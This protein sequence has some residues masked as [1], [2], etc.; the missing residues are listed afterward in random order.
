M[1]I[2]LIEETRTINSKLNILQQPHV[3]T[4]S[5]GTSSTEPISS[6]YRRML[7]TWAREHCQGYPGIV[8]DDFTSSW[9]NG[10]AF[11]VILH[12]HK[13]LN[14]NF[15]RFHLLMNFQFH[16]SPSL[17][18]IRQAF[19]QSNRQ[20][21]AQAFQ[22]AEKHYGITQLIDPEGKNSFIFMKRTSFAFV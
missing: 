12:R 3:D 2:P 21:L 17:I 15:D 11:L 22:F 14:N 6:N 8:I 4:M 19:R 18:D 7:L 13:S 9:R 5:N 10:R 16:F 1:D 20:N